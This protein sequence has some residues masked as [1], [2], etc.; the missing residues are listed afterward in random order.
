MVHRFCSIIYV[1]TG[2][3][4]LYYIESNCFGE[5]LDTKKIKNLN[6][7][8]IFSFRSYYVLKKE[9]L[10]RCK[11]GAIN[12][13]P[14]QPEYRGAGG[15]NYALYKNSKFYGCTAHIMSKK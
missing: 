6:F 11:V 9:L 13:H 3:R 12:F 8:Y 10:N 2:S 14:A 15:I 5:K 7:D 1:Q 4:K